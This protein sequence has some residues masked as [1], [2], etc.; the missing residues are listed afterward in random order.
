MKNSYK[1]KT[2]HQYSALYEKWRRTPRNGR[3]AETAQALGQAHTAA[4]TPVRHVVLWDPEFP[5]RCP[6][7]GAVLAGIEN[8]IAELNA[9]KRKAAMS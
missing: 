9:E 2:P 1:R 5:A 7:Y 6:G 8:M 3:A 4:F